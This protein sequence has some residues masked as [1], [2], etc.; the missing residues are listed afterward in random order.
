MNKYYGRI[1]FVS[2]KEATPGVW[3][4][5]ITERYYYGDI[6]RNSR[7]RDTPANINSDLNVSNQISIVADPYALN[8]FH[9]IQYA[10]FRGALWKVTD[11]EEKFPRLILTIGG[12][13]YG[14]QASTASGTN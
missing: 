14:E 1:G 3:I 11:I 10:E 5:E 6:L 13:Y 2:N 7:R 4:P 12:V 8:T 9:E